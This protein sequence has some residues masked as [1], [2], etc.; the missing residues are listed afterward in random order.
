[1][2]ATITH[3]HYSRKAAGLPPLPQ[4]PIVREHFGI[5]VHCTGGQRP[6][7]GDLEHAFERIRVIQVAH[8]KGNGWLYGGYHLVLL[9]DGSLVDMRGRG[10]RGAH[11]RHHNAWLGVTV[12]GKGVDITAGE[13]DT[14]RW[15][16]RDLCD[17]NGKP[18]PILPHNAF[19]NKSCPGPVVSEWLA[20]TFP[21]GFEDG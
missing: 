19:S 20:D 15:L 12:L 1:M 2:N 17:R 8:V 16:H 14:L 10:V 18:A 7:V 11:A 21:R 9:P 6:A 13:Q 5:V 3:V 4:L